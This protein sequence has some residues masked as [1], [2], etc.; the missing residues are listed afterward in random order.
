MS[1]PTEN[2]SSSLPQN[3][4]PGGKSSK[5]LRNWHTSA[6]GAPSENWLSEFQRWSRYFYLWMRFWRSTNRLSDMVGRE[7]CAI[8]LG[9]N[10]LWPRRRQPSVANFYTPRLRPWRQRIFSIFARTTRSST[11]TNEW[12]R[13]RPFSEEELVELVLS[14]ASGRLN[15]QGLIGIFEARCKPLEE[16]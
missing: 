12:A 11:V 1:V 16:R 3:Q 14:V 9:L 10:R 5:Q 4:Q 2:S 6:T 13:T 7:V 15:K 8:L